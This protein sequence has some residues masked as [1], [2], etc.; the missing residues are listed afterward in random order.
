MLKR[1]TQ[2]S[3]EFY[4]KIKQLIG[5]SIPTARPRINLGLFVLRCKAAVVGCRVG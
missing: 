2:D 3:K 5:L 1:D 4:R